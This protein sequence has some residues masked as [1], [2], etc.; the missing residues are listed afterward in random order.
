MFRDEGKL[1]TSKANRLEAY[2]IV[3]KRQKKRQCVQIVIGRCLCAGRLKLMLI[4]LQH[5]GDL[6]AGYKTHMVSAI[7]RFKSKTDRIERT[8]ATM[9]I[10]MNGRFLMT[11]V[12]SVPDHCPKG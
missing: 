12:S 8:S 1:Y 9:G 7:P 4:L 3:F 5:F 11:V 10:P 2:R 6:P